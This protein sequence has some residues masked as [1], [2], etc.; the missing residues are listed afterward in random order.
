MGHTG[1][2]HAGHYLASL[3]L[4]LKALAAYEAAATCGSQGASSGSRRAGELYKGLALVGSGAPE[5][6]E[7]AY[8]ILNSTSE[9]PSQEPTPVLCAL[10]C[11]PCGTGLLLNPEPVL[12]AL[13]I[14]EES[15][16]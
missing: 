16:R 14:H 3:G 6:V 9:E 10:G 1:A 2:G 7:A 13:H 11:L 8:G 12:R 15:Q 5:A 4:H